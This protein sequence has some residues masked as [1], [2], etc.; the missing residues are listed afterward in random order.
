[1]IHTYIHTYAHAYPPTTDK[2][3][4]LW[5]TTPQAPKVNASLSHRVMQHAHQAFI[6]PPWICTQGKQG[7]LATWPT[8][9]ASQVSGE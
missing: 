9:G 5:F 1:M 8:M 3:P 2:G 7:H 6:S 4:T